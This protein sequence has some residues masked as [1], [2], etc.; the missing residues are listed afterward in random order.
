MTA[1]RFSSLILFSAALLLLISCASLREVHHYSTNA[2]EGIRQ[3]EAI[4]YSFTKSCHDRCL[5]AQL[6]RGQLSPTDCVC[7]L[8]QHADSVTLLLYSAIRGYFDGLARLS[9][10]NLTNYT[11][12]PLAKSLTA[13]NFG[14]VQVTPE[15]AQS[16]AKIASVLSGALTD[17]YRQK[18]IG[19]YIGEAND[20]IKTLLQALQFTLSGNLAGRLETKKSRL[21]SYY[22]DLANDSSTSAYE[23]KNII[24]EYGSLTAGMDEMKRQLQT[25]SK[26]LGVITEGHQKLYE[27]RNTLTLPQVREALLLYAGNIRDL[28]DEFNKLKNQH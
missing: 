6:E 4:N 25:F 2:A 27:N 22:F 12:D 24:E 20:A 16:Y 8:E 28:A 11:F 23:R 18:K 9:A 10:N 14:G 26:S 15:Q 21:R 3:F 13:G 5:T 7:E 1:K 19:T 17:G